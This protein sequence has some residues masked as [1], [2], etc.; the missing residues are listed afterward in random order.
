MIDD[1]DLGKAA[2]RTLTRWSGPEAGPV[3]LELAAAEDTSASNRTLVLRGLARLIDGRN[4]IESKQRL[5]WALKGLELGKR[6]EDKRLFLPVLS[7]MRSEEAI[8]A[9]GGLFKD[10]DLGEDAVMAALNAAEQLRG[11]GS[12]RLK[13]RL[14]KDIIRAEYSKDTV[15]KAQKLLDKL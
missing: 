8:A 12:R 4:G 1:Q 10:E 11:R 14:L 2:M 6:P 15:A 3:F 5:D 13:Q 9:L 7:K